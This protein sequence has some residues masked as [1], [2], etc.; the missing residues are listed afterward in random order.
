MY[1]THTTFGGNLLPK[2]FLQ[3]S[4]GTIKPLTD[5]RVHNFLEGISLKDLQNMKSNGPYTVF[6]PKD[7][8][9]GGWI[10]FSFSL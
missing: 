4:S 2:S 5:Y 10:V 6:L 8:L 3:N 7:I 1:N 9:G